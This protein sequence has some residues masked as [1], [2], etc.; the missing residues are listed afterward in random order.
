MEMDGIKY[1][2]GSSEA[3]LN[4]VVCI[5]ENQEMLELC[6]IRYKSGG[7]RTEGVWLTSGTLGDAVTERD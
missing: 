6:G 4:K 1:L 2:Q 5:E 7:V 3:E